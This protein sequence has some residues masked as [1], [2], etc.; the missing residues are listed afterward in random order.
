MIS[1]TATDIVARID[2]LLPQTQCT[3]CGYAGCTPYAAAIA[4]G[5]AQINQCPPGG[6]E[7]FVLSPDTGATPGMRVK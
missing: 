5:E 1:E 7:I 6:K 2:A 3:R 4:S